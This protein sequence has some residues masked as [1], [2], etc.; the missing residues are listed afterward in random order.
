MSFAEDIFSTKSVP[1]RV[2]TELDARASS[3]FQY[4]MSGQ[5]TWCHIMSMAEGSPYPISTYKTFS[6]AYP[7]A[8]R[9]NIL[10]QSLDV[11]SH[12]E[13]GTMRRA[14][15]KLKVF[16]DAGMEEL[17]KAYFIPNMSVRIQFGW[18]IALKASPIQPVTDILS[19]GDANKKIREQSQSNPTYD[20]FQGR[21][22]SWEF[23]LADDQS[24]DVTLDMIGAAAAVANI[25]VNDESTSCYCEQKSPAQPTP[26]GEAPPEDEEEAKTKTSALQSALIRLIDEP[27]QAGAVATE[28][29]ITQGLY[30]DRL[31]FNGYER[32]QAGTE[33]TSS[34]WY[35]FG[36]GDPSVGTEESFINF[37]SLCRLIERTCA[38]PWGPDGKP[39][40][41][42]IDCDNMDI[43]NY[44]FTLWSADP[45]VC[46]LQ[47]SPYTLEGGGI[48]YDG[49]LSNIYVNCIHALRV[50]KNLRDKDDGVVTLLTAILRDINN[51]CGNGWEFDFVDVSDK[52]TTGVPSGTRITIVDLNLYK[53]GNEAYEFKSGVNGKSN[54]R[55]VEM[56]LKPTE[57]MKTLAL[58]SNSSKDTAPASVQGCSDR[59]IRY[60]EAGSIV[61]LADAKGSGEKPKPCGG[62]KCSEEPEAQDD[63]LTALQKE[64]NDKTVAS[65]KSYQV[66]QR[67]KQDDDVCNKAVMPFQLGLTI[68]GIGG[69]AFGQLV[70]LDR[71]PGTLKSKINYQVTAVEHSITPDD[72]TTK[73]NTVGRL[74]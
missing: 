73:I 49:K 30:V 17:A 54:V 63:P 18:S 43:S 74:K 36:F 62:D 27:G 33:D 11:K 44:G 52:G 41:L 23:N 26:G 12:G 65:A 22:V 6:E 2:K 19:D 4:G 42:E 32:D 51:V 67:R 9:P 38:Q 16:T 48:N 64:V 20:G 69:F 70:T 8:N 72:W 37:G 68:T 60:A 25:P 61:N 14:G 35:T 47:G 1:S 45:R 5:K 66:E 39:T 29:G 13:Y 50:T 21:V 24:W 71:L 10:V 55:S 56:S 59:F 34:P 46:A 28:L 15:I 7:T 53:P 31:K 58:Y 3:V 40:V 57:A